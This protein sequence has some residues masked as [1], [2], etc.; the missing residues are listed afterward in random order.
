MSR[1]LKNKAQLYIYNLT[2]LSMEIKM[3]SETTPL[4]ESLKTAGKK[5][6]EQ[7][8]SQE[9]KQKA[10]EFASAS[11]ETLKELGRKANDGNTSI[12]TLAVLGGIA[13]IFTS[14]QGI[15]GHIFL[16]KPISALMD[17]YTALFGAAALAFELDKDVVPAGLQFD[18][19][20][21]KNFHLMEYVTGRGILYIFAGTLKMSQV[22]HTRSFSVVIFF[23]NFI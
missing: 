15:L 3:S 17:I 1:V 9:A 22:C 21:A 11:I 19:Y 18:R 2:S 8:A 20:I 10:K 23:L 6:M 5:T 13:M 12:R 4:I 14:V 16:L 7:L